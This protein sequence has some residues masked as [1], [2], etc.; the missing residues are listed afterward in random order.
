MNRCAV[1]RKA[2]SFGLGLLAGVILPK[3]WTAV[4]AAVV[5]VIVAVVCSHGGRWYWM[6]RIKKIPQNAG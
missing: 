3:C 6:F 5:L 4:I 2:L 1:S